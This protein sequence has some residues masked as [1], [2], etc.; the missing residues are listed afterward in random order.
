M[1]PKV[2]SVFITGA[3][4]GIGLTLLREILAQIKP[5]IAFATYRDASKSEELMALAAENK[6]VHLIQMDV[7]DYEKYSDVA[8][9]VESVTGGAGLNLLINN[10]G[11]MMRDDLKQVSIDNLRTNMEVNFFAPLL[12]TQALLPQLEKASANAGLNPMGIGRAA[13]VNVSSLLGSI[14]SNVNGGLYPYRASKSALNSATKSM[15]L[16][17]KE[18]QILV[19]S[20]HPGW[21]QTDMGSSAASLTKDQSIAG[22]MSVLQNLNESHNGKLVAWDGNVLPW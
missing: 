21:V 5:N 7:L 10:A 13:I 20:L 6:T 16:D 22:I 4:R 15:S 18:A 17:L 12:L 3:N 8:K 9:T 11:I 19:V 2:N 1:A 14:G